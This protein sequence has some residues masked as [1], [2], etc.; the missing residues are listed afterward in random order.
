MNERKRIA[1]ERGVPESEV[2]IFEPFP[3]ENRPVGSDKDC[4]EMLK[5]GKGI[6]LFMYVLKKSQL[7]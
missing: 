6:C 4:I 5:R 7:E 3:A 2:G 1:E